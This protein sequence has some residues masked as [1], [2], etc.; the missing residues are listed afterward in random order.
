MNICGIDL[1][2]SDAILVVLKVDGENFHH[3]N[4]E[5]KKFH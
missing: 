1:K 2:A 4:L 3:L 5:T